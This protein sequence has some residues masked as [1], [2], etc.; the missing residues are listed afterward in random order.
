MATHSEG[1]RSYQVINTR[2]S[3][4]CD[5]R[6]GHWIGT[7]VSTTRI[8][9][10][11]YLRVTDLSWPCGPILELISGP[12]VG[13]NGLHYGSH[14]GTLTYHDTANTT[15]KNHKWYIAQGMGGIKFWGRCM[16][17]HS[18]CNMWQ[19]EARENRSHHAVNLC[20]SCLCDI[21]V[22]RWIGTLLLTVRMDQGL[23]LIG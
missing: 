7:V 9:R 18:R 10:A 17:F 1:N 4:Q 3:K 13:D 15:P 14:C 11:L 2:A 8:G 16:R 22:C 6:S 19:G 20:T 5:I 23:L 21:H 12:G